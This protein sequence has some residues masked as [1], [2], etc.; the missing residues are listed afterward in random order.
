[1]L[2]ILILAA[3]LIAASAVI[4]GLR[5]RLSWEDGRAMEVELSE[6]PSADLPEHERPSG[7]RILRGEDAIQDALRRAAANEEAVAAEASRRANRYTS[8]VNG[9]TL[10]KAPR[11]S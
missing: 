5:H 3:G 8:R 2:I 10:R 6:S 1:M 4:L 11:A 9:R 7:V